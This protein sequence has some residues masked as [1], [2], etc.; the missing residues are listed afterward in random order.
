MQEWPDWLRFRSKNLLSADF[1]P[2]VQW[3]F[4]AFFVH[5]CHFWLRLLFLG[6]VV[7]LNSRWSLNRNR[8]VYDEAITL[9]AK[10]PGNYRHSDHTRTRY[11][12]YAALVFRRRSWIA[13]HFMSNCFFNAWLRAIS[14]AF[15]LILLVSTL[16]TVTQCLWS[17]EGKCFFFRR[18]VYIRRTKEGEVEWPH[19]PFHCRHSKQ[20]RL[21][22]GYQ[23]GYVPWFCRR[24]Y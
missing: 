23:A 17:V 4:G 21:S 19:K 22:A 6:T 10:L 3:L 11:S 13:L 8:R 1:D 24:L 12:K 16:S 2:T 20:K 9:A 5:S 15:F 7:E 14:T 18:F